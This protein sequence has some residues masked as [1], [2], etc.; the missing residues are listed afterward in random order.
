MLRLKP[1]SHWPI[2]LPH[3]STNKKA[4]DSRVVDFWTLH[5]Q[6]LPNLFVVASWA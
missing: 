3:Q 2:N 1:M 6:D 5:K 4:I